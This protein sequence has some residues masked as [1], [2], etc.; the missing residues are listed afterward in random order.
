MNSKFSCEELDISGVKL[1]TPFYVEDNRGYFLKSIEKDVFRGWELKIDI[2]ETFETYSKKGVIRGLH[3]QTKNPQAKIVRVI[4]GEV[5]DIIVDLRKGSESFG[6][7]IAVNLSDSNHN[8]V[9]IPKGFAHGFEV[10]SEEALVS[11]TCVGK[12]LSEF[13]TGIVWD[14]TTLKIEWKTV[15][16]IVSEKDK[17]LQ[18]FEEFCKVF[19]ALNV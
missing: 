8:I 16:P 2:Y 1:I 10:V 3:F 15:N 13:D 14:D 9:W 11:Y 17:K 19:G 6:K 18:S 7:Y 4:K 5:R 12:Y